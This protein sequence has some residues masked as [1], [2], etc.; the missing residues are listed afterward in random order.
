[1][2]ELT[3]I[4]RCSDFKFDVKGIE[5]LYDSF[6][7]YTAI[8]ASDHQTEELRPQNARNGI[9]FQ[10][11]PPALYMQPKR[12]EYNTQRN[13]VIK[14]RPPSSTSYPFGSNLAPKIDDPFTFPFQIDLDDF[15][16]ETAD[17]T[18]L[19]KYKLHDVRVHSG[20]LYGG[21]CYA[22]IKPD[23]Y[24]RWLKFDDGRATPVT[25]QEVLEETIVE[26]HWAMLS[27]KCKGTDIS[28]VELKQCMGSKICGNK[29]HHS[30]ASVHASRVMIRSARLRQR[31]NTKTYA[32]TIAHW[33]NRRQ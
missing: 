4:F 31:L 17:K 25:H 30:T 23:R 19:W 6:R 21:Q 22:L 26:S 27:L 9:V 5:T 28:V 11:F 2:S 20:D 24:T 32:P 13:A 10:S 14:V 12:Y 33:R 29:A 7:N 18:K 8:E 15:L 3:N 16:D 1:M